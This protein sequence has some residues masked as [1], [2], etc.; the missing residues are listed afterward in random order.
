MRKIALLAVVAFA[1]A[2]GSSSDSGGSSGITGTVNGTPFSSASEVALFGSAN[3]C[4]I[5]LAP[6]VP[7]GLTMAVG[8]SSDVAWT[9]NEALTCVEHKNSRMLSL[10]I[11]RANLV[12]GTAPGLAAG[13]YTFIDLANIGTSPPNLTPDAQGNI[14]IFTADVSGLNATCSSTGYS[15]STGTLTLSAAGANSLTGTVNIT[16]AGGAGTLSGTFTYSSCNTQAFDAC[17]ALNGITGGTGFD[18]CVGTPT[19]I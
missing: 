6:G 8:A 5:A 4:E 18:T 10:I 16:L 17:A 14:A 2:C 19:C 15:V 13:T 1:A 3:T 7:L 12:T 9:C 11:A